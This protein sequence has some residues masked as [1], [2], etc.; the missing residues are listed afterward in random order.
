VQRLQQAIQG[1]PQLL[2]GVVAQLAQEN[3]QLLEAIQNNP[4]ALQ[5]ILQDPNVM[6]QLMGMMIMQQLQGDE[7]VDIVDVDENGDYDDGDDDGGDENDENIDENG[8]ENIDEN[9]GDEY[10]DAANDYENDDFGMMDPNPPQQL[11]PRDNEA[12]NRLVA[13]GF[14]RQQVTEAYLACDK[15]EEMAANYLF[16]NNNQF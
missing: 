3:P 1:N 6:Q 9:G 15:N 11:T 2:A 12:I 8:D 7:D 14:S 5:Q 10:D 13:M 16:D 4:Q